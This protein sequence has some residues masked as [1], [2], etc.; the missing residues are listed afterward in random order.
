MSA[1]R[2][3]ICR[4]STLPRKK[5]FPET[6]ASVSGEDS[7]VA[8]FSTAPK[9]LSLRCPYPLQQCESFEPGKPIARGIPRELPIHYRSLYTSVY[10]CVRW[11]CARAV[12]TGKLRSGTLAAAWTE[13]RD[14]NHDHF[15]A[16]SPRT[17]FFGERNVRKA[18]SIG[19]KMQKC[20]LAHVPTDFIAG[21][22]GAT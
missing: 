9:F 11:L 3:H 14:G 20:G 12:L 4:S 10:R 22:Q 2:S 7:V 6:E 5:S 15:P 13:H 18:L 21:R 16:V 19:V 17:R 1:F 8:Y